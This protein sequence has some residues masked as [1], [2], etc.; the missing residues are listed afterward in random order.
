MGAPALLLAAPLLAGAAAG[1]SIGD[2]VP[3]YWTATAAGAA[4]L[5][6]LAALT[7]VA[8]EDAPVITA[9]AVVLATALAGLSLGMSDARRAYRTSLGA[10]FDR[11][12]PSGPIAVE[13]V[14]AED[15]ALMP[16]GAA[17]VV[18]ATGVAAD[19]GTAWTRVSG[20]LRLSVPPG[21]L[22]GRFKTW[23]AGRRIR[24]R[25]FLRR[26]STYLNP[27]TPDDSRAL[28]RRGIVLVGSVKSAAVVDTVGPGGPLAEAAAG[29][30]A[31][32]RTQ[33]GRYLRPENG[34][35]GDVTRAVLI[36]D[37][38]GLTADQ[39]RKLQDAGTYHVIAISGGNIAILAVTLTLAARILCVPARGGALVIAVLLLFYA[40][41]AGGAPS[42]GRAVTVAVLVLAGR[43]LDH[44]VHP[45]N[46]LAVAAL[47]AAVVRPA[48]VLEAGFLLSFAAS[49]GILLGM[50][51]LERRRGVSRERPGARWL[52]VATGMLL[53]TVC[54]EL[55]LLPV[56]ATLFARA[57]FAG[58]LLNFAAIPLMT[59]VQIGGLA[60]L[61]LGSWAPSWAG[62]AAIPVRWASSG[63]FGSAALVDWA[64]WLA[65]DVPPPGAGL[66]FAYYG[67]ALAVVCGVLRRIAT[68][69]FA[70]VVF[71]L[72]SPVPVLTRDAVPRSVHPLRLV[73][74]DVGQGDATVI[75]LPGGRSLLV[76]AGGIAPFGGAADTAEAVPGFDV[77]ERIVVRALRALGVRALDALVLTHGDPDHILGARAVT[78]HYETA[79]VWEGVPVPPHTGL[80]AFAAITRA[81]GIPW[82]TVQAG[83]VERFGDVEIRV[84][85]PPLP[86]W[87]RQRVRNDD[88]IVLEVRLGAVSVILPGDVGA[89]GERS[90]LRWLERGRTVVLKAPHHGSATSSTP[91][92]LEALRPA[93]VIFSSGRQNR[94]GHPH[95]SVV[96]RYRNMGAALFGT[97]TDGAVFVETDGTMVEV[98]GWTGKRMVRVA[99]TAASLSTRPL[100]FRRVS[101]REPS[102]PLA[103]M[104]LPAPRTWR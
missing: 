71:L 22:E 76:D 91:A 11:A 12:T 70:L 88:S 84:L 39:E 68:P 56:T 81:D 100:P 43:A 13:G 94:F 44:R 78:R 47:A 41:I 7:T 66:L 98:R 53:A 86:D 45:L 8:L 17:L 85:H 63:L 37:R 104:R 72:L 28:A 96:Q 58:L 55:A 29:V 50:P 79:R 32:A 97:A 102:G 27:G 48:V 26:P 25:A 99:A 87:E 34:A 2:S 69:A 82:R 40:L 42:V 64:P 67:L 73:V 35:A 52:R 49:A 65:F 18:R 57:T 4:A 74:L 36:G 92:L 101:P 93:A 31:W 38:T 20:G 83:D 6:W 23:R 77:G 9:I 19:G 51:A 3:T 30:R 33:I 103:R 10:W 5:I 14:L 16:A 80:R 59:V 75:S 89:E 1:L 62:V 24:A 46:V 90:M 95:P 21:L 15:A 61:A 54:A 60:V